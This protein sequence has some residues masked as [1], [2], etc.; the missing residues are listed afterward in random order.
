MCYLFVF[1]FSSSM[2]SSSNETKLEYVMK[3][4]YGKSTLEEESERQILLDYHNERIRKRVA[5]KIWAILGHIKSVFTHY[6]SYPRLLSIRFSSFS[7]LIIVG[8]EDKLVRE[9][10]SQILA[11]VLGAHILTLH[12][13][14]HGLPSEK[15]KEINKALHGKTTHATTVNC[16]YH[17]Y[18]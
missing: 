12:G 2:F 11:K 14:G 8:T 4:L 3:L 13:A 1:Y 5:P 15:P 16:D 6:V 18:H 10:N 7:T 9:I 17:Q